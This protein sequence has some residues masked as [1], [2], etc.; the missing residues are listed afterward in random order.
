MLL[1]DYA[2]R[3]LVRFGGVEHTALGRERSMNLEIQR[4]DHLILLALRRK[5]G[6]EEPGMLVEAGRRSPELVEEGVVGDCKLVELGAAG[7]VIV[8][9]SQDDETGRR[10][11]ELVE[12]VGGTLYNQ[13][14]RSRLK[15]MVELTL[16][17]RSSELL[18]LLHCP[19]KV[20][21]HMLQ[22]GYNPSATCHG[23]DYRRADLPF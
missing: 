19:Q 8:G 20:R 21:I 9:D 1:L 10:G 23:M 5:D 17:G 15:D 2:V 7:A 4:V 16:L 18:V 11:H 3:E 22:F 13:V 12:G 6:V 14:H